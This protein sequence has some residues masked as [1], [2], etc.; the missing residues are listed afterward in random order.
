M[1]KV[2]ETFG[3]R[4]FLFAIGLATSILVARTLGPE[5]RGLYAVAIAVGA[6]GAQFGNFGLHASNTYCVSKNPELLPELLANTLVVSLG[7]GTIGCLATAGIFMA[8]PQIAPLHGTLLA[9]ALAIIPPSLG[10]ML[11]QNLLLGIHEVRKYNK[12]EIAS[13]VLGTLLLVMLV[14]FRA[15]TPGNAVLVS[16]LSFVASLACCTV[17]LLQRVPRL[18]APSLQLFGENIRY[19]AKAYLTAL[20]SFAVL[21]IDLIVVKYVLGAE[22]VGY[23]S[24]AVSM[25]DVMNTFPA[26]VAILLFPKL[27]ALASIED[28][29]RLALK[30][31]YGVGAAMVMLAIVGAL[32]AHPFI[33]LL[34]GS[35]FMPAVPAFVWLM[36][37]LVAISLTS[38]FSAFVASENIP[39]GLVFLYAGMTILNIGLNFVLL[40]RYGIVGASLASVVTYSFCL[41]GVVVTS[42]RIRMAA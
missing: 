21:R 17:V 1:R 7:L 19:G 14:L 28:R 25:T 15:I 40:P 27:S 18:V 6:V 16:I 42:I 26:T 13:K 34:F 8:W 24:I 38:I 11:C 20:F 31:A 29:W 32:A 30:V 2:A 22:P 37:A 12:I 4:V 10:Y 9:L 5:G 39:F 3:T 41:V 23:Y 33:R 36:P 35:A